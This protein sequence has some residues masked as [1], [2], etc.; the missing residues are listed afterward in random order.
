MRASSG[1]GAG[2]RHAVSDG[3]PTTVARAETAE[4]LKEQLR[5]RLA[6]A[7]ALVTGPVIG[8]PTMGARQAFE[9]DIDA[10]AKRCCGRPA[11]VAPGPSSSCARRST[12]TARQRQA[13]RQR[14]AV[15]AAARGAVADRQ[16]ARCAGRL[17]PGGRP[18]SRR[19]R[20]ADAARRAEPARRQA[21]CGRGCVPAPDQARERTRRR[22]SR[23]T[24]AAPCW[25]TCTPRARRSTRRWLPTGR[26][27]ARCWRCSSS[28]A[29][30]CRP[31]AR[32]VRHLRPHRRRAARQGRHGGGTGKPAR[33]TR[34]RRGAGRARSRQSRLAARPVG[35]PRPGRRGAEPDGRSRM[36]HSR[37]SA[38][39]WRSPSGLAHRKRGRLEWHWDLSQSHERLGDVLMARDKPEEALDH[40]RR[41]LA[42]AEAAGGARSRQPAMAARPCRQLSQDRLDRAGALQLG[43]GTRPAGARPRHHRPAGARRLLPGAVALRP[44]PLRRGAAHAGGVS[45]FEGAGQ[46]LTS[47]EAFGGA[48]SMA[49]SRRRPIRSTSRRRRRHRGG[50]AWRAPAQ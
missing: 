18:R 32:P 5:L 20:D 7:P 23:A 10:A 9:G 39:A 33:W 49:G 42:V 43:R 19:C 36:R 11:V 14:G 22:R 30:N 8:A 40:Y 26:P 3:G 12:A 15:L 38:R 4:S 1:G 2:P 29:D 21:R 27:S 41:G 16:H 28:D 47:T 45:R 35:Q 37:A 24:A 31:A 34:D 44:V 50:R 17:F 6:E 46:P 13:Q 25:A 48:G